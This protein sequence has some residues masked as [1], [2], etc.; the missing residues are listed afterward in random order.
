MSFIVSK[1]ELYQ[2][3]NHIVLAYHNRYE[4]IIDGQQA[5]STIIT[6]GIFNLPYF[7]KSG[8]CRTHRTPC[9]AMLAE[10]CRLADASPINKSAY[11]SRIITHRPC[12]RLRRDLPRDVLRPCPIIPMRHDPIKNPPI[13]HFVCHPIRRQNDYILPVLLELNP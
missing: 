9:Y 5:R 1:V 13:R 7:I 8:S 12:R 11:T 10:S 4:F 6:L 3:I 2:S